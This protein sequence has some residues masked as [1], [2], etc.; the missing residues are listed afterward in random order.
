[1]H[2]RTKS[3]FVGKQ[4]I[5]AFN[6]LILAISLASP[7]LAKSSCRPDIEIFPF[8]LCFRDEIALA[9][10]GAGSGIVITQCDI[11]LTINF[12]GKY[13]VA[14]HLTWDGA[15]A[16]ITILSSDVDLDL[17]GQSIDLQFQ[18]GSGIIVQNAETVQI[19][20]GSILNTKT[21]NVAF[22]A[23]NAPVGN[24]KLSLDSN[25]TIS[26]ALLEQVTTA[27]FYTPFDLVNPLSSLGV[28][29]QGTRDIVIENMLFDRCYI[30]I[31]SV[32]VTN[33][34]T[35]NNCQFY[36]CGYDAGPSFAPIRYR[37][38]GIFFWTD[39][40][41]TSSY[42]DIN[43]CIGTST[44]AKN[45]V[46]IENAAFVSCRNSIMKL[47]PLGDIGF[48]EA[49]SA[50]FYL[51]FITDLYVNSC[52]GM[53]GLKGFQFA[54]TGFARIEDCT[55]QNCA[56][57]GFDCDFVHHALFQR[58]AAE[59]GVIPVTSGHASSG[60]ASI[61]GYRNI[62]EEC[63]VLG[64][65]SGVFPPSDLGAGCGFIL[66]FQA[67]SS[68]RECLAVDC[69]TGFTVAGCQ[70]CQIFNNYANDCIVGFAQTAGTTSA[71]QLVSTTNP[72]FYTPADNAWFGNDSTNN[73]TNY[74][75]DNPIL[76]PIPNVVVVGSGIAGVGR[77]ENV[78]GITRTINT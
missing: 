45:G 6:S 69:I 50:G 16:A 2:I 22:K 56:S 21:P 49:S 74:Y 35:I 1:M 40:G 31:G 18:G 68:V 76:W 48:G 55:A 10:A 27:S 46:D 71:A 39:L 11:P 59:H 14:Q 41:T 7:V 62:W 53:G 52:I 66:N 29:L 72:L 20:N 26:A 8:S 44:I 65:N 38:G 30:G 51:G 75:S 58:C 54:G 70:N 4:A 9:A 25:T 77:L 34:S 36:Q 60:F 42:I 73:D 24:I 47:E 64:V 37:G 13:S 19:R 12:P 3:R 28:G 61:E 57:S 23:S 43:N 78:D 32:G 17:N 67:D 15:G 5:F 63:T 33:Q